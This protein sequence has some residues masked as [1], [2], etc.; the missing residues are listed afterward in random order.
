MFI[1]LT[2]SLHFVQQI[3]WE[4]VLFVLQDNEVNL[5][6]YA[7]EVNSNKDNFNKN[8]FELQLVNAPLHQMAMNIYCTLSIRNYVF[9]LLQNSTQIF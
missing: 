8:R 3:R 5:F 4:L 9:L 6:N 7:D 1:P 2:H